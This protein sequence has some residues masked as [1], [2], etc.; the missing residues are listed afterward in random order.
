M[1][2]EVFNDRPLSG[3]TSSLLARLRGN[4]QIEF[5]RLVFAE[6]WG[7]NQTGTGSANAV[8]FIEA[9]IN[10]GYAGVIGFSL[11]VGI[12]LRLF[13]RTSDRAFQAIWVLFCMNIFSA[14]LIGTL[15]SNGMVLL[16]LLAVFVRFQKK[17]RTE[18]VVPGVIGIENHGKT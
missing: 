9:F 4:E 14:G 18:R 7:Q 2:H 3:E 15:L 12:I 8:Y 1:F 13:A 10:F 11:V 16:I 17:Q 6:Q 5:E